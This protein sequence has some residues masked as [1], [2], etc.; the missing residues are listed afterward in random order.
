VGVVVEAA[1]LC[2]MMRGVEKQN[3]RTITSAVRGSFRDDAKTRDEFLFL[4]LGAHGTAGA[5]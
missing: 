3:S 5:R 2:M 4:A 1:H